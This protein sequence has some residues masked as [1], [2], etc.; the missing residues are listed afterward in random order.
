MSASL[1]IIKQAEKERLALIIQANQSGDK[2]VYEKAKASFVNS[3]GEIVFFDDFKKEEKILTPTEKPNKE[4]QALEFE[5][6]C[7]ENQNFLPKDFYQNQDRLLE[8]K[9]Q[10]ETRN[11]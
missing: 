9:K 8:L 10:K 3:G 6:V 5:L 4:I 2:A 11:A 7:Q 1:E